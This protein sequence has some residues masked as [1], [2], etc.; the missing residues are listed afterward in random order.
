MR[1]FPIALAAA[2]IAALAAV[3]V[4]H[5]PASADASMSG[6]NPT[7]GYTIHIDADQHY[8]AHPDEIIHHWCKP[9]ADGTTECALYDGDGPDARLVGAETVVPPAMYRSFDSAE[10][11]LWHY[12]RVEIPKL[13]ASTPG[14]TK[15]QSDKL[16][17]SLMETYGK[18][19]IL[20]DPMTSTLPVGQPSVTILH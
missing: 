3:A 10:Q 13:H 6:P 12:H 8:G 20:W 19:W 18:V 4:G 9:F 15:E 7:G 1:Y 16:I 14:L 11:K 17:A 2:G 5:H